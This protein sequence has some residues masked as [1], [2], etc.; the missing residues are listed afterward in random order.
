MGAWGK[1][2]FENDDAMD[3]VAEL[4]GADLSLLIDVVGEVADLSDVEA[5]EAPTAS[6]AVAAV[7]IVGALADG[8]KAGLP[9]A[10]V[11]WIDAETRAVPN[12][13]ARKAGRA[14]ERVLRDSELNELWSESAEYDAW[15]A[16][17]ERL[18]VRFP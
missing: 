10:V 15:K 5:L 13:L 1:G 16:D 17:I 6:R 18:R 2:P 4:E 3:L 9:E 14:L 11:A 7:A 12:H 8:G